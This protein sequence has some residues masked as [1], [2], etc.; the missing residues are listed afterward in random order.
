[1]GDTIG[2]PATSVVLGKR[3]RQP[4]K[5]VLQLSGATSSSASESDNY[6]SET[7]SEYC[8]NS[9]VISS[10]KPRSLPATII[11]NGKLVADK[12]VRYHCTYEG[13]DR[14]YRKPSRLAEHER[15]HTGEVST[16]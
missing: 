10:S 14:S 9:P 3:R 5:L 6:D 16:A 7:V 12:R 8:P 1:M 15:A 11:V 4:S 2:S 13:C